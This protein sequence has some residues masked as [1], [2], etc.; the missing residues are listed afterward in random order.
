VAGANFQRRQSAGGG[1]REHRNVYD[2]EPHLEM[3]LPQGHRLPKSGSLD[4]TTKS[5]LKCGT[6]HDFSRA[7][8]QE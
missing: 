4:G 3:N 7:K 1:H 6:P 8:F 2:E 5:G